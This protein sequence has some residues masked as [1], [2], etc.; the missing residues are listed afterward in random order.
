MVFFQLVFGFYALLD[1]M[2]IELLFIE[3]LILLSDFYC[4]QFYRHSTS[5]RQF[6]C[7]ARRFFSRLITCLSISPKCSVFSN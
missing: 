2:N 1:Q 7:Y 4:C 5:T 6:V 3:H